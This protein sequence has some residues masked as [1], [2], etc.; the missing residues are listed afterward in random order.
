MSRADD[1]KFL[2]RF[3]K[4]LWPLAT[5]VI[6]AEVTH[7]AVAD[8][9]DELWGPFRLS[10]SR[11]RLDLSAPPSVTPEGASSIKLHIP[12]SGV[13]TLETR[14]AYLR[15]RP[16]V[17][18]ELGLELTITPDADPQLEV[19]M[20]VD[21]NRR[22]RFWDSLIDWM[23]E[24]RDGFEGDDVRDELAFFSSA[25]YDREAVPDIPDAELVYPQRELLEEGVN[26]VL[27]PDGFS[28]RDWEPF[29]GLVAAIRDRV[30]AAS[31]DHANEPFASFK[32]AVH[33]WTIKPEQAPDGDH[34]IGSYTRGGQ[35][36]V[37]LANLAR[38]AAIGRV[39][40]R[41]WP[42]PTILGF[43][44][45][46]DAAHF[47][48][49]PPRAMALGTVILQP[50]RANNAD[51]FLHELGHTPLGGLGD[52]YVEGR[53]GDDDSRHDVEYQGQPRAVPNL[54]SDARLAKWDRWLGASSKLPDW[55]DHPIEGFEGAGYF[56][57]GVWRPAGDCVMERSPVTA[58]FCAVCR[59]ALTNGIHDALPEGQLLFAVERAAG[60][61]AY[62][63]LDASEASEAGEDLVLPASEPGE[64]R[65]ALL[66]ATLPEPWE[67]SAEIDGRGEVSVTRD[68]RGGLGQPTPL[69]TL[70]VTAYAHDRLA[71]TIA[72]A[73]PF[74][75]WDELPTHTVEFAFVPD[76]D[77]VAAP[78][79]PTD[80]E[81]MQ[82][83]RNPPGTPQAA[84]LSA[85][86]EDPNGL[87]LKLQWEVI[88]AD[89][90]FIGDVTEE[91][92]WLEGPKASAS[93]GYRTPLEGVYR[94]RA[95]ARNR[96]GRTSGWSEDVRFTLASHGT[97]DG[98]GGTGDGG[99]VRP[100]GGGRPPETP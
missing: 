97:G 35:E 34:V 48:S 67:V 59:E 71:V 56:G 30:V 25:R 72:S 75:P 6:G 93:V 16:R 23:D 1:V 90:R 89:G 26:L 64:L 92:G 57:E 70:E 13:N 88:R 8:S 39:A 80:V 65:I 69:T 52:E 100:P 53:E 82:S 32:T 29:D 84:R 68:H 49:D 74:T 24:V 28:S 54:T 47:G 79:R 94:A 96:S 55:D 87:E 77:S 11:T 63:H 98:G 81:A 46:P 76:P 41:A 5:D 12:D 43:I 40:E 10:R 14:I 86:A 2:D 38:L 15:P 51:V 4:D 7:E 22:G 85:T 36:R 62:V 17:T 91:S 83:S 61:P 9:G 66:A 60:E 95:R 45:N 27:V 73:C 44:A 50:V 42:G 33:L 18:V 99:G 58:P 21:T 3:V 19:E 78:S 31:D 20:D 37:A